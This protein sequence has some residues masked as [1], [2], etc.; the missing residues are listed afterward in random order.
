MASGECLLCTIALL[1]IHCRQF[2]RRLYRLRHD[3]AVEKRAYKTS[4]D[5]NSN[6]K[7]AGGE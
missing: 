1:G 5:G 6:Q 2:L 4:H 7:F 3:L